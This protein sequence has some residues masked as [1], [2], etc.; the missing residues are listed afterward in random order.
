MTNTVNLQENR[1]KQKPLTNKLESENTCFFFFQNYLKDESI[2]KLVED[3]RLIN[4]LIIAA[5]MRNIIII[6]HDQCLFFF[7]FKLQQP[8]ARLM[9]PWWL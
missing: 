1:K 8:P 4:W 9:Q 7:F 5:V 6:R 3:S 2:I